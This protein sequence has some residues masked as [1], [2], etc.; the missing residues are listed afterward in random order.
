ML[1]ILKNAKN[2]LVLAVG[3][4][5]DSV[6]TLLLQKQLQESFGYYPEKITV[7]AMLP[8]CLDYHNLTP[9]G[10][11]LVG[12]IEDN[13]TRSVQGYVMDAFPE[14]MLASN[15]EVIPTLKV[16]KVYGFSMLKGSVGISQALKYIVDNN[17]FDMI[18]AIDV[19]GDFI[20]HDSNIEV[21]SPMMDGYMLYALKELEKYQEFKNTNIPVVY[22]IFGLGTDGESTPE[23]LAKALAQIPELYEGEFSSETVKPVIDFYRQTVEPNRYSR[24]TDF[25]IREIEDTGHD[26]PAIFRGRFHVK[27]S[28]N[29]KANIHYGVFNHYQDSYYFKKYYV[30]TDISHITNRFA[31]KCDSGIEWFLKVQKEDSKINHELNGQSYNLDILFDE[32]SIYHGKTL[33]FGTPSRKFNEDQQKEIAEEVFTAVKNQ[34]YD[35]AFIYSENIDVNHVEVFEH[36]EF[37]LLIDNKTGLYIMPI[38]RDICIIGNDVE[39]M[40]FFYYNIANIL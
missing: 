8:D 9:T 1:N 40:E 7:A 39:L 14:R 10:H 4:G 32:Y 35:M 19:G 11:D 36:A 33:F 17:N 13:T 28:K 18:L 22:S 6:S 37:K 15:K 31:I 27:V 29:E 2:P 3:G 21:L 23:M 12:I 20:A 25:T 34:V 30:F 38:N 24:T 5:N 16:D 26:N